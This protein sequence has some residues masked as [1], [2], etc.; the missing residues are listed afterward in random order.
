VKPRSKPTP[1]LLRFLFCEAIA[2]PEE[3]A[4]RRDIVPVGKRLPLNEVLTAISGASQATCETLP[5][6][7]IFVMTQR[8]LLDY[9]YEQGAV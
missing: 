2:K 9:R 4:K 8:A 3:S 5:R 6:R 1:H 7:I